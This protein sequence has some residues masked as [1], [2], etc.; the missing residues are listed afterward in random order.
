ME[1][2]SG[3]GLDWSSSRSPGNGV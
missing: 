1:L 3:I 2:K